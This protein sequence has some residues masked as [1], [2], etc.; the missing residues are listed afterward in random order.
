MLELTFSGLVKHFDEND[1]FDKFC[2]FFYDNKKFQ[3]NKQTLIQI[4]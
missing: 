1:H 4:R 3:T 2:N